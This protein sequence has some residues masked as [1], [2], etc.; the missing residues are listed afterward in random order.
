MIRYIALLLSAVFAHLVL[1]L[2]LL[3][4]LLLLL[5]YL[6]LVFLESQFCL[7]AKFSEAAFPYGKVPGEYLERGSIPNHAN[8]SLTML[9]SLVAVRVCVCVCWP[10]R[11]VCHAREL[12]IL[13]A[14]FVRAIRLAPFQVNEL[15]KAD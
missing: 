12:S 1:L 3:L 8:L 4:F 14:D 6:L 11:C 10:K 5:L 2:L 7:R 13:F 15:I 9:E